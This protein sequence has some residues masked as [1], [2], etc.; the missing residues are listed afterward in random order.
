M[1]IIQRTRSLKALCCL[2]VH[3]VHFQVSIANFGIN[4]YLL[5]TDL[6]SKSTV[7]ERWLPSTS[8]QIYPPP[9]FANSPDPQ[10][11]ALFIV[12]SCQRSCGKVMFF[13]GVCHSV[14]GVEACMARATNT[15]L[16][17]AQPPPLP[18]YCSVC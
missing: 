10:L 1:E 6:L 2:K 14:Y 8:A 3:N 18:R 13:T 5:I 12:P 16:S 17:H 11:S 4:H 15:T 9:H 7:I